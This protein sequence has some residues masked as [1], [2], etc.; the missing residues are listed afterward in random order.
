VKQF[1]YVQAIVFKATL[2]NDGPAAIRFRHTLVFAN[3]VAN[4]YL[5]GSRWSDANPPHSG[6]DTCAKAP[7][8]EDFVRV[9]YRPDLETINDYV[10]EL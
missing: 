9:G 8:R 10:V 6:D 7:G 1:L 2:E 5:Q 3:D 4:A